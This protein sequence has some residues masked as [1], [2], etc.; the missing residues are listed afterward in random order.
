M[1]EAAARTLVAY[2]AAARQSL[3]MLPTQER[4]VVERFFDE[5]GGMQLVV[6]SPYGGRINRGLG[7]LLRKRFCRSFD[8]ELQA[9]ANDDAIVLS[10]GPQHGFPLDDLLGFLS[11]KGVEYALTHAVLPTPMFQ[12]R[13]R[14]NLNRSLL[15]LRYKAGRK[16]PPPIQRM[17]SDDI[18]AAIFPSLAACQDNATGP[19]EIPDH[20][21]VNQTLRDCMTEAMDLSALTRLLLAIAEGSVS[22]ALCDTTEPSLLSHEI[23]N[24]RPY[25]FLDDAPLEERRTRAVQLRRG[26][27]LEARDL[28]ALDTDAIDRVAR[29][30]APE[31]RD[32]EELHDLL[33]ELYLL[34]PS[35]D[36]ADHFV[37]L[38]AAGRARGLELAGVTFWCASERLAALA[39]LFPELVLV[40]ATS[41]LEPEAVAQAIARAHLD[42]S[43]PV[44]LSEL[45]LRTGLDA[46]VLA[47][48]LGALERDGSVFSGHF[49]PRLDARQFC[50]RRLLARIHGYTQKRLR[51]EIEPV[52]PRDFMRFLL[53]FH[54]VTA[55]TR[56]RGQHGV[57]LA[58]EQLQG[59]E[60]AAPA[61][62]A[63][64]L[65]A[66]VEH[67]EP[68]WL[69][70]HCW[71]GEV[72][73]GR[74]IAR[75]AAESGAA[76][77]VSLATP[78]TLSLREDFAWLRAA[79][80]GNEPEPANASPADARVEPALRVL[81]QRGASFFGELSR[82]ADLSD[83]ELEAALWDGVA[84]GLLTADGFAA[85][86]A[87][88]SARL[89]PVAG[90]TNRRRLRRGLSSRVRSSQ[91]SGAAFHPSEG[92]WAIL[93][94]P[95]LG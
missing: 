24:G 59:F 54:H 34:R 60:A 47:L 75:A 36:F 2:L 88:F 9:A 40:P 15:V 45:E 38:C 48:A 21:I 7:L 58:V 55:A 43:G 42:V 41:G 28:S 35:A 37:G 90:R 5:T 33:C 44:V 79:A 83:A 1:S 66:R 20:P 56:R 62:E 49:D 3:G 93:T 10:L 51:R 50:A 72:V 92:R 11:P 73:W 70:A 27:P 89:A 57:L 39:S 68:A 63:E 64:L 8:F 80:H 76:A 52:S 67:Y 71:S 77:S 32:A 46:G 81:R 31:P 29:E 14:W 23:I 85:L 82:E 87:L 95:E 65:P 13:W 78:I 91:G 86:R 12:A 25:T 22:L 84:R 18:M 74:L 19:R 30:A 4:L 16:N 26:I 6:H 61:W 69:D 53:E 94:P 17:E